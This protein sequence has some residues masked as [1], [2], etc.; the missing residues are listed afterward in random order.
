MAGEKFVM[1]SA[2]IAV[3]EFEF[4]IREKRIA[5]MRIV[6]SG[7]EI[8]R[9]SS[10]FSRATV[11]MMASAH[12]IQLLQSPLFAAFILKPNL[13]TKTK[14]K[15]TKTPLYSRMFLAKLTVIWR[16]YAKCGGNKKIY[17]T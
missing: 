10:N 7:T 2:R 3:T 12:R 16:T 9:K 6:Q 11:E 8:H 5:R 4:I 15:I 14:K 13:C 1:E 17:S